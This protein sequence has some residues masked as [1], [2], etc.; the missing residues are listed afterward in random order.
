MVDPSFPNPGEYNHRLNMPAWYPDERRLGYEREDAK[1]ELKYKLQ[2]YYDDPLREAYPEK[3]EKQWRNDYD[4]RGRNRP[5][6]PDER[7]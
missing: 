5:W 3:W 1:Q 6:H 2:D 4:N 7:E